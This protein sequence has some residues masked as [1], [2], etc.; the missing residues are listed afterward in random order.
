VTGII[1]SLP[2]DNG[3]HDPDPDDTAQPSRVDR[4]FGCTLFGAYS[5]R[6]IVPKRQLGRIPDGIS[7]AKTTSLPAVSLIALST[8]SISP[9]TTPEHP[10]GINTNVSCRS[11]LSNRAI[12]IHLA[13]RRESEERSYKMS[14][15][16]EPP[17]HRRSHRHV[18]H[19]GRGAWPWGATSSSTGAATA[20]TM[21]G[22]GRGWD[23]PR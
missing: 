17:P 14:K 16:P 10:R 12:L 1:E 15:D 13:G 5:N 21:M 6:I 3:S 23:G 19:G 20:T 18:V 9:D 8:P 4:V 22:C 2:K 7:T 11:K